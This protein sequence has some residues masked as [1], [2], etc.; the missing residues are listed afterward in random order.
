MDLRASDTRH[1]SGG[2][3]GQVANHPSEHP[4]RQACHARRASALRGRGSHTDPEDSPW[5]GLKAQQ[6]AI[7]LRN[8]SRV[9]HPRGAAHKM[10]SPV[11]RRAAHHRAR[12]PVPNAVIEALR[13]DVRTC[14][15]HHDTRSEPRPLPRMRESKPSVSYHRHSIASRSRPDRPLRCESEKLTLSA[16]RSSQP[17]GRHKKCRRQ[18]AH[19]SSE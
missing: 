2:G 4:S 5:L 14:R 13:P 18:P 10:R 11:V 6:I 1:S 19:P 12:W 3:G 7:A 17:P 15:P 9:P 8:K 16:L